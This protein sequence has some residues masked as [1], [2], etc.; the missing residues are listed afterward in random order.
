MFSLRGWE[1]VVVPPGWGVVVL[2]PPGWEAVVVR[3][4]RPHRH[5]PQLA[6]GWR[7]IA[8]GRGCVGE[9]HQVGGGGSFQQLCSGYAFCREVVVLLR[10]GQQLS[11]KIVGL[12]EN[13]TPWEGEGRVHNI[14]LYRRD[15]LVVRT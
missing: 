2:P 6:G 1:L 5:R 13:N 8:S 14:M 7:G 15:G 4:H 3:P 9:L 11:S 10:G 12:G